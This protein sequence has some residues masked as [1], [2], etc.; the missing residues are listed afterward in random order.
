MSAPAVTLAFQ[1]RGD[2]FQNTYVDYW[3][4]CPSLRVF[5]CGFNRT[6]LHHITVMKGVNRY[7]KVILDAGLVADA[8]LQCPGLY[9]HLT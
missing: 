9:V 2:P 7:P 4:M 1:E 6:V 3:K 8:K 5:I